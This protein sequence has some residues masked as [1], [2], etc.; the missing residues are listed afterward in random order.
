MPIFPASELIPG[1]SHPHDTNAMFY[2]EIYEKGYGG[3]F[4]Y[5]TRN[6][7]EIIER[8]AR[9]G[10][11]LLDIGAGTGRLSIP[12]ANR[13]FKVIAVDSSA[14]MADRLKQ[15]A[16]FYPAE[17]DVRIGTLD[18]VDIDTGTVDMAFA[19]HT[20]L[21]YVIT[22]EQL[23]R[24]MQAVSNALKG[25]GFFLVDFAEDMILFGE[26][27]DIRNRDITITRTMTPKGDNLFE[28]TEKVKL[29]RKVI[30]ELRVLLRQWSRQQVI[31]AATDAGLRLKGQE[32]G[33]TANHTGL[34][35]YKAFATEREEQMAI[36]IAKKF[37]RLRSGK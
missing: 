18:E 12:L 4:N 3:A 36:L 30:P 34:C 6:H 31:T 16:F 19:L 24:F 20:V 28:Y 13:K 10:D 22:E 26:D 21:N 35:F 8:Y 25:A 32:P 2:D 17:P 23:K 7:L 5:L 14:A 29:K 27:C 33:L 37:N 1:S 15:K 11:V 9:P